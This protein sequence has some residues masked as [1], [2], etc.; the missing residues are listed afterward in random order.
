MARRVF[1]V[2]LFLAL[3]GLWPLASDLRP[4]SLALALLI[5]LI[6][7]PKLNTQHFFLLSLPVLCPL[8]Y[9]APCPN[10]TTPIVFRMILIS[11]I[12]DIFLI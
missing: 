7:N 6:Q 2:H 3:P 4:L 9:L 8:R 1:D 10:K 12:K 11:K 5:F